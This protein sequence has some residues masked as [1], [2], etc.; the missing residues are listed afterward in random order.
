MSLSGSSE[1]SLATIEDTKYVRS[2]NMTLKIALIV[3][4]REHLSHELKPFFLL[5]LG[6]ASRTVRPE[7]IQITFYL[8]PLNILCCVVD[9]N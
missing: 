7:M 2:F 9:L 3:L 6:N 8:T 5:W 4:F 1:L